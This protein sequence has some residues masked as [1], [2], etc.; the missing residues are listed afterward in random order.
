MCCVFSL[1]GILEVVVVEAGGITGSLQLQLL[2][3][4]FFL[5]VTNDLKQVT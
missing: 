5:V 4:D 2:Q 1:A 3:L